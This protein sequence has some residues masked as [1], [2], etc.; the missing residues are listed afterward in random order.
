WLLVG[1]GSCSAV[2]SAAPVFWWAKAA[3]AVLTRCIGSFGLAWSWS[4]LCCSSEVVWWRWPDASR[5]GLAGTCGKV[6]HEHLEQWLAGG[7]RNA[8]AVSEFRGAEGD[9]RSRLP[10]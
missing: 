10:A 9:A 4:L 7:A 3:P 8:Q 1:W 6:G 5:N 2:W